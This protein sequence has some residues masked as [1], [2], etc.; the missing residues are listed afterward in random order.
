M[1]TSLS[2]EA[3]IK[4]DPTTPNHRITL[5]LL[6]LIMLFYAWLA[7]YSRSADGGRTTYYYSYLSQ[8]FLQGNLFLPLQADPELLAMENPYDLSARAEL[9]KKGVATPVD[10]SLYEGKFYLYW[11][12]VPALLLSLVQIFSRGP[13]P[14]ADFFL[15]FLFGIGILLAQTF[16][17]TAIWRSYF[18]TLPSWA[19]YISILLTGL[20]WPVALL[21]HEHN[22]ARIYE[23][24]IAAGQFFLIAGLWL[25]FTAMQK[26]SIPSWRLALAGFL[27]LLA[28]GSRH[29]LLVSISFLVFST[30]L[31][32]LHM[33]TDSRT[34]AV[35]LISLLLPLV[36]GGVWL[37]WYNWA[38]FGSIT[39]TG[40]SYQL[41]GVDLRNHSAE[42]FSGSY[43]LQNAYN[44]LLNPPQWSPN[45]PFLSMLKGNKSLGL[46]FYYA[47]PMTG[48]LYTL[49]FAVFAIIPLIVWLLNR[50]NAKRSKNASDDHDHAALHWITRNL[51]STFLVSFFLLLIF[52]WSGMRYAADFLPAL[53][54]LSAVG[55][56]RG[57]QL[58]GYRRSYA[59]A[60]LILAGISIA[61]ST[62][63]AIST[64]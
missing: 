11:G 13:H 27:W 34:K 63:L 1:V 61:V 19:Y 37:A 16:L 51:G 41:A 4:T 29:T 45:F 22:Y 28:I 38:R 15:A 6:L 9:E 59:I 53:M 64:L 35:K 12:P 50:S 40:Y 31:W 20:V 44:Y 17:L 48:L 55:F 8:G 47:E 49:P 62:L 5:M 2:R 26:P 23:A 25:A 30:A 56:W 52:F 7:T 42:L 21:R 18:S 43:I 14:V 54:G 10:F 3:T 24:A 58:F 60:G 32:I 46:P 36:I 57:Y 39:E 33:Q